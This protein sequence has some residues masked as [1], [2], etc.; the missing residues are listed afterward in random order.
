MAK[1]QTAVFKTI[2][3]SY[4]EYKKAVTE[5]ITE[6]A[7]KGFS[8]YSLTSLSVLPIEEYTVLGTTMISKKVTGYNC[9]FI[10]TEN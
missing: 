9:T 1:F 7:M 3:G 4:D 2:H 10:F 8:G 5:T 6:Y